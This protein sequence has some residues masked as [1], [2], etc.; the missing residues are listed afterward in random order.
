MEFC[1]FRKESFAFCGKTIDSLKRNVITPLQKWMEGIVT[2][3]IN[4]SKNYMDIDWQG[5]H[6]R[7]YFFGGRDESSYAL[8]QGMTLAG[9]LMDEV[10]LMPRSFVNQAMARCSV[11]GSKIWMNC[12]PDGSEEHWL[13][14]EWIDDNE[15]VQKKNRL[16]LHFTME[17]NYALSDAV[18]QR[19]ERMF[20]GVFYDRYIRGLWVLADG[21]VYPMFQK[22]IH[23][24]RQ[25][26]DLKQCDFFISCD[27]GTVNPTSMGLWAVDRRSGKATRIRE[28]YWNSRQNGQRRT[29]EEHYAELVR[30]A[31]TYAQQIQCIVVDP[32]AASFIECIRR[33][34]LFRVRQADNSVTDGI[35]D[36]STLLQLG[37]LS[38]HESCVDCIRE[39]GLYC[40]DEKAPS[41]TVVKEHDHA[42]DDMRYF[43][44]TVMVR[45]LR[46]I[47]QKGVVL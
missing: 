17:D 28:Y 40:W 32:S 7:Y 10:A 44:R 3:K 9:V 4:L 47:R 12:N 46:E 21:L 24:V 15:I 14:K 19:Y 43:V 31:G 45:T 34:H 11:A 8:V 6:N 37:F 13:Y 38:F 29:D 36:T 39:F 25:L 33:H 26:P 41:D 42:M 23:V 22:E 2:P 20:S 16:H 18:R 35:R 30:L 27:Y 1:G 5:H